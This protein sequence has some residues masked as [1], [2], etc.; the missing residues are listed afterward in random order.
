[1]VSSEL[2]RPLFGLPA[3][4]RTLLST[5]CIETALRIRNNANDEE[6]PLNVNFH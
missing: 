4:T 5:M 2:S 3:L 6:R 1:V